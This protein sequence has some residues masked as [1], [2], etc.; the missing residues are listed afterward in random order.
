MRWRL[1][2]VLGGLTAIPGAGGADIIGYQIMANNVGWVDAPSYQDMLAAYPTAA[3]TRNEK[4]RT[5]IGCYFKADGS[6]TNCR[7]ITQV[8]EGRGFGQASLRLASRFKGPTSF[9]NGR[10]TSKAYVMIGLTFDAQV[11]TDGSAV[12]DPEW[13][14]LPTPGELLAAFPQ[15]ARAAD[16][17]K[18]RA[19]L[20]C[21]VAAAGALDSCNVISESPAGVGFGP[22]AISLL[23]RFALETWTS[24]GFPVVGGQVVV[25]V[26]FDKSSTQS[27]ALPG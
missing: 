9:A 6:L 5:Y 22:A 4:G 24:R 26:L 2:F 11:L 13:R 12:L 10:P 23:P 16:I 25:P 1:A 17:P 14:S 8:P 18:G 3:M 21:R 19:T 7:T 15:A 20:R 27:P